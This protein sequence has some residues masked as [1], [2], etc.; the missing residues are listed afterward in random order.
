MSKQIYI[1]FTFFLVLF[2]LYLFDAQ[3]L[4]KTAV[5]YSVYIYLLAAI[6][7]SIPHTFPER[8]GFVLPVQLI[9][10]SIVISVLM[11]NNSWDQSFT[12]SFLEIIPYLTWICFF[13]LLHAKV[14]VRI[15]ERIIIFYG[16]LYV[17]LYFYQLANSPTVLFGKSLWGDEFTVDRGI[18]RIIFPGA[19]IFVLSVF[20]SINKLTTERK[21]RLFWLSYSILGVIIPFLQVTRQFIL[22][23][24]IIYLL[25]FLKGKSIVKKI[26]VTACLIFSFFYIASLDLVILKGLSEAAEDDLKQGGEYI[27]VLAAKYFLLDFS[28]D[29]LSRILGNGAPYWGISPYGIFIENLAEAQGYFLS[30]VG[31]IGMYAM[32]GILPVIGFIMIWIKSI[33]YNLPE[34]K[35]YLKYYLWYLLFTSFTWFTVYHYHYIISTVLVLYL[36]QNEL[37]PTTVQQANKNLIQN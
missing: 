19:G 35:Y 16:L 5:N 18:T 32:F 3:F 4:N 21:G 31:I 34:N 37:Y 11:A 17:I 2:A 23:I 8:K 12:D 13:Y 7:L 14:P 36:Y 6:C 30:D 9:I 26:L 15:I 28:P 33:R 22:G 29:T 20:L 27:R 25:H 1:L 10:I 24:G